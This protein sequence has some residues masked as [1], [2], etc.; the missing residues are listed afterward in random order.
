MYHYKMQIH[1]FKLQ[2]ELVL[3]SETDLSYLKNC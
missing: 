3:V 1:L 2:L